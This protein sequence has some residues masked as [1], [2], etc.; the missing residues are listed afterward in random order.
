[1]D[2]TTM[3]GGGDL[4]QQGKHRTAIKRIM[5][6]PLTSRH[7]VRGKILAKKTVHVKVVLHAATSSDE[8]DVTVLAVNNA[9]EFSG[10]VTVTNTPHP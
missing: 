2:F 9:R 10:V 8:G 5:G 1:M 7:S 6:F 4:R 3:D